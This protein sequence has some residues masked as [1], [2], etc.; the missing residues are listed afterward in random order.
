MTPSRPAP[1]T[2]AV[3]GPASVAEAWERYAVPA[4][5]PDWSPQI[6]QVETSS[7]RLVQGLNG[8]VHGPVPLVLPF[9]VLA[10]D[11]ERHSW[12]WRVHVGPVAVRMDHE[13]LA[14]AD[15]CVATLTLHVPRAVARVYTP[16]ARVALARLVG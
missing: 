15:G 14:R 7:A 13:L 8:T 16:L 3:A 9:T 6:R 4:R 11:E 1:P 12:S 5:W 10:V 2:I